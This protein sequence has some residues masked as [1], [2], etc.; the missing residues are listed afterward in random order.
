MKNLQTLWNNCSCPVPAATIDPVVSAH[1]QRTRLTVSWR[2]KWICADLYLCKYVNVYL[3]QILGCYCTPRA[4]ETR[5][6][7]LGTLE[8]RSQDSGAHETPPPGI[9]G[10][11]LADFLKNECRFS[12]HLI[13]FCSEA[14]FV[15][16]CSY[17]L[18]VLK[19]NWTKNCGCNFVQIVWA[20]TW[21]LKYFWRRVL[22]EGALVDENM[23]KRKP[24]GG[25]PRWGERLK[26]L[27]VSNLNSCPNGN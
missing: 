21:Y 26:H 22:Q 19:C 10:R 8:T 24:R 9:C 25:A 6:L 3:L 5:V 27:F 16:F 11:C 14:V 12:D 17:S 13:S 15:Y 2:Q 4:V 20:V 23:N 1:A 7:H 18:C